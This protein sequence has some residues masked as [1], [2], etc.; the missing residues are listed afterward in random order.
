[1]APIPVKCC[2]R[3]EHVPD[4]ERSIRTLKERS[5][6]TTATLPYSHIPGIM[7]DA[8]IQ[9]KIKWLNQFPP[10]DYISNVIGPSGMI[11]GTPKLDYNTL[12]L[13]FGQ[14]CQVHDG[15]NN[16]Q[17]S[18]SVGAIA[19]RPKNLHGSYYFMSLKT[20]RQ[21][22]SNNWIE[23]PITQQVITHVEAIAKAEGMPP[24]ID[25]E[26]F[27]EW[28][29]GVPITNTPLPNKEHGLDT[30]LTAPHHNLVTSPPPLFHNVENTAEEDQGGSVINET[31]EHNCDTTNN[32]T[33]LTTTQ[34]AP[35]TTMSA[36]TPAPLQETV[37]ESYLDNT[38]PFDAEHSNDDISDT[39]EDDASELQQDTYIDTDETAVTSTEPTEKMCQETPHQPTHQQMY[40]QI[41]QNPEIG[42]R[43]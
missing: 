18:R 17:K 34:G 3:D 2:G 37:D 22:H 21:I 39:S 7:V 33:T 19:L 27:F 9:D 1:M 4:I 6:C 29:P 23:L 30:R 13:D 38:D 35:Q 11:L 32:T 10:K 28:E 42:P 8:N 5:R 31:D 20:G 24:L 15:T 40:Q 14:Y 12:K 36:P 26:L 25:G 43:E 16:T 41:T